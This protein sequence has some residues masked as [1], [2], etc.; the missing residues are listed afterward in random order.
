MV[1]IVKI[2]WKTTT[3]SWKQRLVPFY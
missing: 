1:A 2:V 3:K